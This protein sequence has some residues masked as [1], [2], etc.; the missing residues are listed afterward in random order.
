M[1]RFVYAGAIALASVGHMVV[2]VLGVVQGWFSLDLRS[3]LLLFA[4]FLL[5]MLALCCS[6][7]AL[8]LGGLGNSHNVAGFYHPCGECGRE[9]DPE[10]SFCWSCGARA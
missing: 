3:G 10:L 1:V 5:A 2:L 7:W 8:R 4:A 9:H 6:I